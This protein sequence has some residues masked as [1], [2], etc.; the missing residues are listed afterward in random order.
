M[1]SE[2]SDIVRLLRSAAW[3][4]TGYLAALVAID[5]IMYTHAPR[6]MMSVYYLANATAALLFLGLSYWSWIEKKLGRAYVPLM[7]LIISCLPIIASRLFMPHMPPGPMSNIEGIALRV[8]PVLF[9]ALV[10]TAWQYPWQYVVLFSIGTAVLEIAIVQA[11]PPLQ[12]SAYQAVVFIATVRSVSFLVVGYFIS[13]LMRR[14][15]AQQQALEQANAQLTHYASTLEN[16]TVSRE[17][18]RVARELHD[19]LAHTLSGLAVQL[20]TV[21]AYWEIDPQAARA[22]LE[23]ALNATRSGLQETRR[24]LKA[25]RASPLEDLGLTLALRKLAESA[26]ERADLK[27]QLALPDQLPNLS[28]DVEQCLYRI[29]QEALDNTVQHA[30]AQNL[31]LRL[32]CDEDSLLL[33][34]QDDGMGFNPGSNGRPEHLGRA[35]HFGLTG[36]RERAGLAGGRLEI[37]SQPGQGTRVKLAMRGWQ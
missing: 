7:L 11:N 16:L 5:T 33:V 32:S 27:L 12:P 30:N 29:A 36:M 13:R 14:L 28:P 3:M 1:R 34:V 22:Q 23:R 21:K 18:N 35:E 26:A 8:L 20:E 19:T 15:R 2:P 17:R 37:E 31:S 24:A 9:M 4:W 10:I 25:L 6:D